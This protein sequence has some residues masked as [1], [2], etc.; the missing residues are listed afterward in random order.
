MQPNDGRG[1][2]ASHGSDVSR[3]PH[4][5][6]LLRSSRMLPHCRHR[7][8]SDAC[9]Q[10]CHHLLAEADPHELLEE[11]HHMS[12]VHSRF[13]GC[14]MVYGKRRDTVVAGCTPLAASRSCAKDARG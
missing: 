2:D 8:P 4:G 10:N 3:F 1:T 9:G 14:R 11:G 12:L 6:K 13:Q 7:T 5:H